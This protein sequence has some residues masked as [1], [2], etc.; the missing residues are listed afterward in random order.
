[1][2]KYTLKELRQKDKMT[3]EEVGKK[4]DE[5]TWNY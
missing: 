4:L 5:L 1:M 3:L 2:K